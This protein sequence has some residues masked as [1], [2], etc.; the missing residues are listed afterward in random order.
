MPWATG[1]VFVGTSKGGKVIDVCLTPYQSDWAHQFID[2]SAQICEAFGPGVLA[3]GHFGSTV[4]PGMMAKPVIDMLAVVE[5]SHWSEDWI[6]RLTNCGYEN[7]GELGIPGRRLFRKGGNQRS[8]HLQYVYPE[9]HGEIRR[10]LVLRDFLLS[11]PDEVRAYS[12]FKQELAARYA[13][14][15]D[16]SLA[17]KPYVQQLEQRALAWAESQKRY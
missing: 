9:G 3:L 13:D 11:H 5:M 15:R 1:I 4:V 16:Y 8:H 14:T 7:A 10:H 12:A 2:E 6:P 17:K